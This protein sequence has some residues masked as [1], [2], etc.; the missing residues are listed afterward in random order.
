MTQEQITY[1]RA[2]SLYESGLD[3]AAVAKRLKIDSARAEIIYFEFSDVRARR[4]FGIYS[5]PRQRRVEKPY[6]GPERRKK[7]S[8]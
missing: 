2:I 3:I 7:Y 8:D 4:A 5:E 6:A 1:A